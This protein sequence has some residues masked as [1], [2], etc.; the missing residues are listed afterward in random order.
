MW[1]QLTKGGYLARHNIIKKMAKQI[2]SKRAA[3]VNTDMSIIITYPSLVPTRQE[4][5]TLT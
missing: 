1:P 2:R 4:R 3:S 5:H